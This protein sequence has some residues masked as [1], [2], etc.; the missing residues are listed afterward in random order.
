EWVPEKY[1]TTRTVYHMEQKQENYT[2]YRCENVQEERTRTVTVYKTVQEEKEVVHKVCVK[3]QCVEE[4]TTY[5]TCVHYVN[6]NKVVRKCVD[7]GHWEC[8]EVP[9]GPGVLDRVKDLCHKDC[10]NDCGHNACETSCRTKKT[11]VWVPCPVW[12]E[13]TVCC[14]KRVC[15]TKPVT[16]KVNVCKTQY[17]EEKA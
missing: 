11:R 16:C 4:R 6:E 10:C 13:H 1:E 9:C 12:E 17:R 14:K 7:K 15:E 5:K 2:S 3:V 8:R